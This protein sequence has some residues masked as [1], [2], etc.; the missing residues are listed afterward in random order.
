MVVGR[1]IS[2]CD[3]FLVFHCLVAV[4]WSISSCDD[5]LVAVDRFWRVISGESSLFFLI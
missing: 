4:E 1:S 3:K 2:S 5:F